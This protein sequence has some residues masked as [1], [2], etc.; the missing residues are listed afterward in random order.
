VHVLGHAVIVVDSL[1][2]FPLNEHDPDPRVVTPDGLACS[3]GRFARPLE[4]ENCG[5]AGRCLNLQARASLGHIP[6][7]AGDR[8]LS[9]K[10]FA[11]L[12]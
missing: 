8:M 9:E 7:R 1:A 4:I 12:Q 3:G 6:D 11:R 5:N 10:D 2:L